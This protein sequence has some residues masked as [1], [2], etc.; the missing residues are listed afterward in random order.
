MSHSR[1]TAIAILLPFLVL[2]CAATAMAQAPVRKPNILVIFGDDIG[3]ANISAYTKGLMGYRTPNIDRLAKEGMTFTDYYA[4]Q[5]RIPNTVP[6]RFSF[7]ETF[8]VSEDTG[9]PVSLD[10]DVPF[11]FTGQIE[12]VVVGLGESK[13][14]A[15]EGQKIGVMER[16]GQRANQ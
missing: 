14:S 16:N 11:K 4:E 7:D 10:Y 13:L 9:T 6:A 12:K 15:A 3:Q 1:A 5:G 8:D 2:A